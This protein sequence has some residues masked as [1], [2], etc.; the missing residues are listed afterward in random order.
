MSVLREFTV[1]WIKRIGDK[2][3]NTHVLLDLEKS[4]AKREYR[5]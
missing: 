4:S 1:Y 3:V 5:M 2:Q